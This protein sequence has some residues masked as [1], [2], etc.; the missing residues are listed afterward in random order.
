[1]VKRCAGVESERL[2]GL[3]GEHGTVLCS[4]NGFGVSMTSD[5]DN[6]TRT[7]EIGQF[8]LRNEFCT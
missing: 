8:Q 4:S 7:F 6:C 1:M 2:R 5:E 3:V